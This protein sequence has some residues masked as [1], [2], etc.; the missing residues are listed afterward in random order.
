M[1]VVQSG[2]LR[3]LCSLSLVP[4]ELYV[5]LPVED[6]VWTDTHRL[7]PLFHALAPTPPPPPVMLPSGTIKHN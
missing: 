1:C 7:A 2:V 5:G 6:M 3:E 4:E